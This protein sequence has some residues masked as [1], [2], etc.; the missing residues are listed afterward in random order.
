M[1][2]MCS[3]LMSDGRPCGRQVFLK[4]A[5][6]L[7]INIDLD[8]YVKEDNSPRCLMHSVSDRKLRPDAQRSFQKEIDAILESKPSTMG[9][10][11]NEDTIDFRG[12]VFREP[13]R[14]MSLQFGK[15]V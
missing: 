10:T 12:F 8:L 15:S 9:G 5:S 4:P 3:V 1:P 13:A 6:P 14:F 11:R 7:G 2:E